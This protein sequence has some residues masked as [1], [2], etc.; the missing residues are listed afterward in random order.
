VN[1]S[2]GRRCNSPVRMIGKAYAVCVIQATT[3]EGVAGASRRL[4]RCC[5]I[6]GRRVAVVEREKGNDEGRAPDGPRHPNTQHQW[7]DKS[8]SSPSPTRQT[9][10]V[11]VVHPVNILRLLP[12]AGLSA[13]S[14]QIVMQTAKRHT[15]TKTQTCKWQ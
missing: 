15:R 12:C 7:W 3:K 13:D 14:L 11:V 5:T 8:R 9:L 10:V 1:P 2:N 4:D 6:I